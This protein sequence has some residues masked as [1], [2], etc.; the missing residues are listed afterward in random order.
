MDLSDALVSVI[1]DALD[2]AG[3]S[4]TRALCRATGKNPQYF[5]ERLDG[6]STHTGARISLSAK[7]LELIAGVVH[8][9]AS[10]LVAR[11]EQLIDPSTSRPVNPG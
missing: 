10:V 2:A 8:V 4:S 1:K 11:A 7:D 6:G 5:S 9:P 3:I